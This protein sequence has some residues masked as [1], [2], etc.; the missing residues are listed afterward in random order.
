MR[1]GGWVLKV[2][3]HSLSVMFLLLFLA[4]M[5]LHAIGGSEEYSSEQQ[6]HGQA[7]VTVRE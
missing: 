6:N 3:E 4:S 1:R 7:P 5:A 2:Y